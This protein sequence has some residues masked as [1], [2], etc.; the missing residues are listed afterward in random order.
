MKR[1]LMIAYHYPPLRGS[2]GIQRTLT[3]SRYL[4]EH[5]WQPIVLTAHP[6]A[7]PNTGADQLGDIPRDVPVYRAFALDASRHLAI[8]GIYPKLF[9][10]PD[11]FSSWCL[12]GIPTGLRI[13]RRHQPELLWSTYPIATAHL[14]GL[15]LHSL[16]GIPWVA[17][18]R[19]SMTEEHYPP[20]GIVRSAY[21]AIERRTVA[22][23][24]RA[25]FTTPG[26]RRM[27]AE[28]YPEIPASRWA[29]VPNGYDE[30]QFL[31][32]ERGEPAPRQNGAPLRLVHSGIL[33][34]SERDP[35]AFFEAIA[36]LRRDGRIS[37]SSVEVV[38]RASEFDDHY[39]PRLRELEIDDIV[40]LLPPVGYRAALA[41]MLCADGLLLFQA[42]N[43]NHQI[44]AKI[45]EYF[46]ARRPILGMTDPVGDTAHVL[47]E[48]GIDTVVPLDSKPRIREG[49]LHF[50]DAIRGGTAPLPSPDEIRR[51]AR[52]SRAGELAALFDS[53]LK[54]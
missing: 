1:V 25:V 14:I 8:R 2:S 15:S 35:T 6:R 46:R 12:G 42:S 3:L 23:A 36:S 44:P 4:R 48:A 32:A 45:Y 7:Y 16:S 40:R 34:P 47:A 13:L 27:Y 29:V 19:D 54:G 5:G 21:L 18:F 51:H 41:E 9:A 43:C 50:L 39:R 28:R 31:E 38:L 30:E 52:S 37:A 22:N 10:V 33:Y 24:S 11:R 26:T 17:D 20:K 53:V 49:L